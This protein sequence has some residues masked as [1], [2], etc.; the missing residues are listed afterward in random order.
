MQEWKAERAR[1]TAEKCDGFGPL[2]KL[3]AWAHMQATVE[4]MRRKHK[5][6]VGLASG[7]GL[8]GEGG[9]AWAGQVGRR[10]GR[11]DRW[12]EED[13]AQVGE[14]PVFFFFLFPIFFS[15]SNLKYPN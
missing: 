4:S 1:S 8:T 10:C 3:S 9:T 13:L 11:R 14:F 2:F 7:P 15:L 6:A 12:A 5:R